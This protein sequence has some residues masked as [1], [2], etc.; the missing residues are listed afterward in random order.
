ME[1]E[2][3]EE[4][5]T[6]KK[7]SLLQSLI[8]V[9]ILIGLLA[10]NVHLFGDDT[11]AGSNQ[12]ALLFAAAIAGVIA[13]RNNYVWTD[14]QDG[15]VKSIS[16]AMP[17]ILILLMIGALAGTWLLRWGSRPQTLYVQA[18]L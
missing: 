5:I 4:I 1:V 12:M 11:L 8:P 14:L 6:S 9:V 13:I 16:S 18:T 3:K 15:I 2:E 17:A 10:T 7:P